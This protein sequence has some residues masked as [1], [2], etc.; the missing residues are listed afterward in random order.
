MKPVPSEEKSSNPAKP[1]DWS[2]F[3]DHLATADKEGRRQWLYP[4]KVAESLMK[5][6]ELNSSEINRVGLARQS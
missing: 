6:W 1:V 2:D 5:V 4:R 3:R